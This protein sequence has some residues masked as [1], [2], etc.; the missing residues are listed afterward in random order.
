MTVLR[1]ERHPGAKLTV[2]D[3]RAIKAMVRRG[4]SYRTVGAWFGVSYQQV[5]RIV[6]R[7]QWRSLE[8]RK[9]A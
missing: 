7:M 9:K 4:D 3:V 5:Y 1:G 6:H 8:R 2:E